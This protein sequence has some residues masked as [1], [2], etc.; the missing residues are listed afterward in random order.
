MSLILKT[1]AFAV[2]NDLTYDRRMQRICMALATKGFNVTL[3][4]RQIK[5]STEFNPSKYQ[6]KRLRC[7]IN[8][9][10]LFYA[11]YNLRLFFYLLSK[12]YDVLC[13]CDLDTALPVRLVAKLKGS[14]SVYDAHEYFTEVPE[15]TNRPVVKSIW[16]Q[17]GK[18]TIPKF[19]LRYTVGEELANLMGTKYNSKFDVIRNI[20]PV[21][22]VIESKP[23]LDRK[24]ILLYQGAL[25]IGR[26]L[27][28]IV[29]AMP[30]LPGWEFWLAGEGDITDQLKQQVENAGLT[31]RV[32]FLGWVLPE[33]LPALMAQA[34]LAINLRE[35]GSLND[36]YSLPNKFFDAI[37]A[38]LPSINMKF[39]EYEK[40]CREFP[41]AMLIENVSAE[42]IVSAVN[43]F[44]EDPGKLVAM[45]N[46]CREAAKIFTWENESKKLV[47]LY[48]QLILNRQ[49]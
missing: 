31:D 10:F 42:E 15:V 1:I 8:K 49:G 3:I 11:E 40:A 2:T 37:H 21:H 33:K 27:E 12:K 18:S 7:W 43:S 25:N 4:G 24:R 29:E 9:G 17:I 16:E 23:I 38:G 6:A 48:H 5:N 44:D 13:A 14:M 30:Q 47:D 34:R 35:H 39:P 26:G 32:R 46:A 45:Q 28:A 36:F 41:C 20:A 22:P 19:N